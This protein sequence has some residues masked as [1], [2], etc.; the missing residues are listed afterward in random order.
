ME[1][2]ERSAPNINFVPCVSWVRRGVAKPVPE[3]VKLT[4]EELAAVI[5]QTKHDL[6][7]LE[8]DS[9]EDKDNTAKDEVKGHSDKKDKTEDEIIDEYGLADYDEEEEAPEGGAK[10]L[11]LGDLTAFADPREDPY[12][13]AMDRDVGDEDEED[14][15]DFNIRS[16]DNLILAGHVEGDSSMLEVYVYNDVEDALYVHHDILLQSFPLALEWLSFD[17]ENDKRGSLVA[18]NIFNVLAKIFYGL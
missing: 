12:L 10:L 17:P 15:E 16:T 8:H 1:L 5:Q 11:G 2:D 6:A 18:V 13:A 9:D 7:D 3:R 4:S 14:V